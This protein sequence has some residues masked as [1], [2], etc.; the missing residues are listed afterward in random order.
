MLIRQ[1][2]G[3]LFRAWLV[4]QPRPGGKKKKKKRNLRS[5]TRFLPSS[6]PVYISRLPSANNSYRSLAG[7]RNSTGDS[8]DIWIVVKRKEKKKKKKRKGESRD[9]NEV[10]VAQRSRRPI[11]SRESRESFCFRARVCVCA[12]AR[13]RLRVHVHRPFGN[14]ILLNR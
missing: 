9:F 5:M 4:I 8:L 1:V 14:G 10:V 11:V 2:L 13:V 7:R 12:R 6:S 3:T